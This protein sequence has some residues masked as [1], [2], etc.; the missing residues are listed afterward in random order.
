M[1][2]W[3]SI[4]LF[5]LFMIR[6]RMRPDIIPAAIPE[7]TE[8]G[9]SAKDERFKVPLR[10]AVRKVEKRTMTKISSSE[11]PASIIWGMLF[12]VP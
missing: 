11:A 4:R 5:M 8:T 10:L 7:R 2:L 6:E 9:M 12:P 3:G 1:T